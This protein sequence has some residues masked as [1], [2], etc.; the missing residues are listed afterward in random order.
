MSDTCE[1][2]ENGRC[3]ILGWRVAHGSVCGL[4]ALPVSTTTLQTRLAI[5]VRDM[6][7]RELQLLCAIAERVARGLKQYG[8]FQPDDKRDWVEETIEEH[9]DA[10]VYLTLEL[11]RVKEKRK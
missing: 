7:E 5:L 2:C 6:P 11:M 4:H 1:T 9:L 10:S 8:P 3:D